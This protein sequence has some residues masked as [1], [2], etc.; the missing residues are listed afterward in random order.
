M[1]THIV[2]HRVENAFNRAGLAFLNSFV[3]F[4]EWISAFVSTAVK[5]IEVNCAP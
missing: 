2:H 5:S 3:R 4:T 1:L